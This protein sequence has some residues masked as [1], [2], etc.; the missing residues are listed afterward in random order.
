M[1]SPTPIVITLGLLVVA[2]PAQAHSIENVAGPLILVAA[3]IGAFGGVLAGARRFGA[4]AG[5]GTS[6]AAL[7]AVAL[8][9]TI[10]QAAQKSLS[11]GDFVSVALLVAALVS[12]AGAIP[13]ALAFFCAYKITALLRRRQDDAKRSSGGSP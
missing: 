11:L 10:V 4:A 9:L 6:L 8:F 7:A 12:L 5:L 13:L 1:R 2:P 3:A